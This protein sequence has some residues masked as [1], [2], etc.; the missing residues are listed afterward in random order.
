L[1]RS[2]LKLNSCD[3]FWV[4]TSLRNGYWSGEGT[5]QVKVLAW[6]PE[7]DLWNTHC[8]KRELD[9]TDCPDLYTHIK[10]IVL[11]EKKGVF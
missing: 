3:Q 8:G 6:W 1:L 4:N 10:T 9:P 7:F 2:V 5:Q 11:K